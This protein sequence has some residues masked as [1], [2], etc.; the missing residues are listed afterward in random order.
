HVHL[1]KYLQR[2]S[3]SDTARCPKCQERDKTVHHFL[4][5][6]PAYKRQRNVLKTEIGPRSPH[7]N[8]LLNYHKGIRVR[9][10][11]ITCTRRL[12]ETFGEV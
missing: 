3:N 8:F 5:A 4:L 10:D 7:L 2:I 11:Y 9:L 12:E 1:S 6:Y